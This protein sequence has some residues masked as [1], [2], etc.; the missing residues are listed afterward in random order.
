MLYFSFGSSVGC[1]VEGVNPSLWGLSEEKW[2]NK[3]RHIVL[4]INTL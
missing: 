1:K 2:D 4:K 3:L